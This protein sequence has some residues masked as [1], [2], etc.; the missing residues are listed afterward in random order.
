LNRDKAR[1]FEFRRFAIACGA[2][3]I[4]LLF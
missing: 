4:L 2:H 3:F 1:V